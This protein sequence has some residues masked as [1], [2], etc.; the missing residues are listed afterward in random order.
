MVLLL[1]AVCA[2]AATPKHTWDLLNNKHV[3]K[4]GCKD[5]ESRPVISH[6][7]FGAHH[8]MRLHTMSLVVKIRERGQALGIS[9]ITIDPCRNTDSAER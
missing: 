1:A 9:V 4:H 8:H 2:T 6:Q 5:V 7:V 3:H